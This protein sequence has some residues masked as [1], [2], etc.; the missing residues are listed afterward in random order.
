MFY[1]MS[2]AT[3]SASPD[4]I[5]G[6]GSISMLN[7]AGARFRFTG[8]QN[9]MVGPA[10]GTAGNFNGSTIPFGPS[11]E[12]SVSFVFNQSSDWLGLYINGTLRCYWWNISAK[13]AADPDT[14]NA[15]TIRIRHLAPNTTAD[16]N[17]VFLNST[18]LGSFSGTSP[19]N[20]TYWNILNFDFSQGFNITGT[21]RLRGPFTGGSESNKLEIYV[22]TTK[23]VISA[24]MVGDQRVDVGSNVSTE[25]RVRWNSTSG[26]DVQAGTLFVNSTPHAISNGWANFTVSASSVGNFSYCVTGVN[27]SGIT[28]ITQVPPDPWVVFDMVVFDVEAADHRIGIG[29]EANMTVTGTYAYDGTAF[30]GTV[31]LNDT[32]LIHN[33]VGR[34][35]YTVSSFL[36]GLYGLTAFTSD[37]DYVIWD[38]VEIILSSPQPRIDVGKNATIASSGFYEYDGS[39]FG[40]TITLND[41]VSQSSEAGIRYFAVASIEDPFE[42]IAVFSSN[43]LPIIWDCI[44]IETFR[45]RD[46]R[47]NVGDTAGFTVGGQYAYDGAPWNGIYT[48]NG[49]R[50]RWSAGAYEYWITSITDPLYGLTA[51]IQMPSNS[52][53]VFDRII[54]TLTMLDDRIS[55]G[56]NATVVYSGKYEYDGADWHG[57]LLLNDSTV[58]DEVGMYWY[59]AA[60]ITDP[61]Y[62]ITAFVSNKTG[63]VFDRVQLTLSVADE[64]IDVGTTVTITCS[65]KY[66]YD[67][68]VWQGTSLLNNSARSLGK[69]GRIDYSVVSITD[70]LYGIDVFTS[71]I[72]SCIWDR[73]VVH[74]WTPDDRINVGER[75]VLFYNGN[76]EYD[77]MPWAG[78][79]T[80]NDTIL[81]HGTVGKYIYSVASITD[82]VYGLDIFVVD[83]LG[84]IFDIL[85]VTY[86]ANA[87]SVAIG[88]PVRIEVNVKYLYDGSPASVLVLHTSRN[89]THCATGNFTDVSGDPSTWQY[90]CEEVAYEGGYGIIAFQS[91]SVVVEWVQLPKT[92]DYY[93]IIVGL[94]VFSIIALLSWSFFAPFFKRR[95]KKE[96]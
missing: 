70:S 47:I 37:E 87:T 91:N 32:E 84:I 55:V 46:G 63:C 15:M 45:A 71:N 11:S 38:R 10:P 16:F 53:V 31:L 24:I 83:E 72:A 22:G 8:T 39:T 58:K 2:V 81:D 66:E 48:L 23:V 67:G 96:P 9:L 56:G 4:P 89:G 14:W 62:G 77:N 20:D 78:T 49:P 61:V 17:N 35:G 94:G 52:I 75:A 3:V 69:V 54:V 57:A 5:V 90:T 13:A 30:L 44:V 1:L 64:R 74:L 68:K 34:H 76:Y 6:N 12:S 86:T 26:S 41:T 42:G 51:F 19:T 40:G 50:S 93:F 92:L 18:P 27:A 59:T 21:L 79:A 43:S 36:D 60:S 88:Q 73:V 28:S 25:Y 95:R 85:N 80:L 65:G 7:G 29:E 33:D 82:P